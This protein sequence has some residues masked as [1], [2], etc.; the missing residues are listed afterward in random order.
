MKFIKH[1]ILL[2]FTAIM[3]ALSVNSAYANY[4]YEQSA[5]ILGHEQFINSGSK[6]KKE[7]LSTF[8]TSFTKNPKARNHNMKLASIALDQYVI[9]P[10]KTFSFNEVIG[11]AGPDQG[12]KKA[13][14]FV[15]G[16]DQK[17]YGGGICQVSSTLYNAALEAGLEIVERHP[18]SKAVHYVEKGKDAAT[19]YGTIDLKFKNNFPYPV[20]I[21]TYISDNTIT[22]EILK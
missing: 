20:T 16:K 7:I 14:I 15:N 3:A 11:Y 2:I 10:G 9:E 13:T 1:K 5:K 8:T 19:S 18:H 17:A 22:A 4:Y 12:Y 21:N 6:V